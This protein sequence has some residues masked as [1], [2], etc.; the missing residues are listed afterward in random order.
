M[1]KKTAL[2]LIEWIRMA[3]ASKVK[4]PADFAKGMGNSFNEIINS[5]RHHINSARIESM[6]A[7]ISRIQARCCGLFDRRYLLL[8]WRQSYFLCGVLFYVKPRLPHRQI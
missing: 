3:T 4:R 6:N 8:K 7:E 1:T 5:F 2:S